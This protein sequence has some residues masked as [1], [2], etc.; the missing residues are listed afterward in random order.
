MKQINGIW[1]PD[2][3]TYFA[4]FLEKDGGFQLDHLEVALKYVKNWNTALDVGAHIGTW[5]VAMAKRFGM[6]YAFEPAEDVF[7]CLKMNTDGLSNVCPERVACGEVF[8]R[9][10][11]G[12]D[13]QRLGNTGSRF[14]RD[15]KTHLPDGIYESAPVGDEVDVIRLDDRIFTSVDLLKID[16]EGYEPFVLNGAQQTILRHKP[17]V[18]IEEKFFGPRFGVEA[19]LALRM[20]ESWGMREVDRIGKDH[21]YVF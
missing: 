12:N 14:I 9:V 6:V 1:V 7:G 20:L 5:S 3:D 4:P 16:A 11:I 15:D 17:V 10:R 18:V 8:K 2:C 19:G 21:V 13:L